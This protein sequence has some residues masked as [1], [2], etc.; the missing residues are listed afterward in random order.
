MVSGSISRIRRG[1]LGLR[2]G[3]LSGFSVAVV[4]TTVFSGATTF[5]SG[6]TFVPF[7]LGSSV[8]ESLD[9]VGSAQAVSTTAAT[10]GS[11]RSLTAVSTAGATSAL[12][13]MKWNPHQPATAIRDAEEMP[14]TTA[15][16]RVNADFR[17]AFWEKRRQE[18]AEYGYSF[19]FTFSLIN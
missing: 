6:F 14:I 7:V 15:F 2:M 4:S 16:V 11:G 12:G 13:D 18:E 9:M 3:F 1:F 8:G 10:S 17:P 5:A 19:L